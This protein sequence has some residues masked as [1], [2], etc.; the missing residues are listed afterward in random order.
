MFKNIV[1]LCLT[2]ISAK[3]AR[4]HDEPWSR[5]WFPHNPN[6]ADPN[7]VVTVGDNKNLYDPHHGIAMGVVDKSC[8]DGKTN[9]QMDWY[10]NVENY[11]CYDDKTTYL[12]QA[13]IHPI[14]SVEHIPTSYSA[15]H[16]CLNESIDY[17]EVIPTFGSHRPL[18]A[19][20]GEY[21]FLPR[22]RWLHN[23]EHGAVAMLYHPC[24]NRN[25]VNIVKKII[26]SC[27]Y[28]HVITPYNLLT[29]NRPIALVTWGHR[30]ELSKTAPEVVVDF[31]RKHALKG[32]E[33]TPRDGQYGFMLEEH[34]SIVSNIDDETLC[35]K[36]NENGIE[37]KK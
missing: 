16:K 20:Y 17:N 1:V 30:L 19:K 22:Q 37:M 29:P 31:I 26:K 11:T 28:R 33:K 9:L 24:A 13:T 8:D 14:H 2:I 6:E 12:P 7:P 15:P 4:P 21:T 18:W 3:A 27:L 5:R 36:H 35:P 10:M 34:A 25:E 32:H 23:L